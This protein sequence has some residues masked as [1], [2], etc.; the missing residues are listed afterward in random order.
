MVCAHASPLPLSRRVGEQED[1]TASAHLGN[2]CAKGFWNE[3]DALSCAECGE[4]EEAPIVIVGVLVKELSGGGGLRWRREGEREFGCCENDGFRGSS[5]ALP[6]RLG[7]DDPQ[8][9]R[10][11]S[12]SLHLSNPPPSS[13]STTD[14]E[15]N[16][17]QRDR[18]RNEGTKERK[19]SG[20]TESPVRFTQHHQS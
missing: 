19:P 11:M 7:T 1:H 12:L 3:G 9:P 6:P 10:A 20:H 14:P 5:L 18:G 13:P 2:S 16:K 4:E 17:I 15:T 8:H